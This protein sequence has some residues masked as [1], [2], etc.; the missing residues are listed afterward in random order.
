[1][2]D[3]KGLKNIFSSSDKSCCGVE[4]EEFKPNH[5]KEQNEKKK[6]DLKSEDQ[7]CC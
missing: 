6:D 7:S 5:D 1:M 3:K 4:F 2:V